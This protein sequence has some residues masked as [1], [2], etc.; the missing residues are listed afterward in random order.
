MILITIL[1]RPDRSI[2]PVSPNGE[3]AYPRTVVTETPIRV[4][5][6]RTVKVKE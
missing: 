4:V 3:A 5:G 2:C 1:G 6:W